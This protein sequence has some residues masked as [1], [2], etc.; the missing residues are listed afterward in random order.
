MNAKEELY[1]FDRLLA[2]LQQVSTGEP[3]IVLQKVIEDV[4]RFVGGVEQ[5][6][7][8]TLVVAQMA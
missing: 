1:G 8:L 3:E 2:C 7:D 4:N 6:D 5:H